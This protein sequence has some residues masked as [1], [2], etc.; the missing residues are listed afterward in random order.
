MEEHGVGKAE[1]RHVSVCKKHTPVREAHSHVSARGG[2]M[3]AWS[4]LTERGAADEDDGEARWWAELADKDKFS[5]EK[6]RS[7]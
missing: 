5:F 6:T 4:S 2:P 1:G 3:V 7:E